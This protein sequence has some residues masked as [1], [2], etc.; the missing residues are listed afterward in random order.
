VFNE[1]AASFGSR[2]VF[3]KVDGDQAKA[4]C[5]QQ[6][7][8]GFPTFQFY[9]KSKKLIEFSGADEARLRSTVDQLVAE[10]SAV[11]P[12]PYKH[13]PL[14][15][16][17]TVSYFTIKWELVL[18]KLLDVTEEKEKAIVTELVNKLKNKYSYHTNPLTE[19]EY[20]LI[21]SLL[22]VPDASINNP[23]NLLRITLGH[24]LAAK[25]Y[26][27]RTA[28][29]P[30]DL[31]KRLCA[32]ATTCEK[33][34]TKSLALQ[35]MCNFF[36]RRVLAK[37]LAARYEEVIDTIA[38]L[39]LTTDKRLKTSALALLI[40]LAILFGESP[41]EYEAA[42]VHCLTNM[43][44]FLSAESDAE[45]VYRGLV[46]LGTLIYLD[47]SCTEIASSLEVPDL[48]KRVGQKH[49]ADAKINACISEVNKELSKPAHT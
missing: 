2:A 27:A 17:E 43:I 13:F 28:A 30:S 1:L 36:S 11:P 47:P 42:K 16:S 5:Q 20:E 15:E 24:P 9:V 39:L 10:A 18:P 21:D 26:G 41:K 34:V 32:L 35:C 49:A 14:K 19:H 31:I 22:R 7:I 46:I 12:C 45:L 4:F 40:N 33:E 37:S 23:L 3:V 48:V 44:E 25:V 29:H 6:E 8:K 38:P